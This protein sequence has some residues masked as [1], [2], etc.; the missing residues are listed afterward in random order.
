MVVSLRIIIDSEIPSVL[1]DDLIHHLMEIFPFSSF[2]LSESFLP[3]SCWIETRQQ[4]DAKCLLTLAKKQS[5]ESELILLLLSKNI[6]VQGRNVTFGIA[7]KDKGAVVSL[8][9]LENEFNTILKEIIHQL[10]HVYG[11]E[12]CNIPCV[13]TQSKDVSGIKS[14]DKELCINCT[15]LLNK[16]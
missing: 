14:K 12:H 10:G 7:T 9:H 2:A 4:F 13:M 16:D 3:E 11:L 8:Y 15:N 1:I 6:Y 5:T